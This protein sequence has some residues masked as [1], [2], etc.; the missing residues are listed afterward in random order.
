MPCDRLS[1]PVTGH[2][3]LIRGCQ[4]SAVYSECQPLT[5]RSPEW[6]SSRAI[7]WIFGL[8]DNLNSTRRFR[9]VSGLVAA[10]KNSPFTLSQRRQAMITLAPAP[11]RIISVA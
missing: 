7:D 11:R 9:L 8:A 4:H 5:S 6:V 1:K 10:T 3:V 2:H